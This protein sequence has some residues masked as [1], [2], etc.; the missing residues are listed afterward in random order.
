METKKLKHFKI[1]LVRTIVTKNGS[2][3]S[4]LEVE[5]LALNA[6]SAIQQASQQYRQGFQ[7]RSLI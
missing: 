1:E 2:I 4:I 6:V 3:Q 5:I 7:P